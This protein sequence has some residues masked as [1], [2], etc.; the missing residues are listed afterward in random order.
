MKEPEMH[1][2]GENGITDALSLCGDDRTFMGGEIGS[3]AYGT[4]FHPRPD[5]VAMSSSTANDPS[6]KG[7]SA[8]C[9]LLWKIRMA[10]TEGFNECAAMER[11]RQ[12]EALKTL[13]ALPDDDI[14]FAPSGTD[15]EHLALKL[16]RGISG[17]K[18]LN[19]LIA[20]EEVGKGCV[21]AARGLHHSEKLPL[22]GEARIGHSIHGDRLERVRLESIPLRDREGRVIP[23]EEVD[24]AAAAL[25]KARISE[26]FHVILHFLDSSKTSLLGP[27][28]SLVEELKN[29][30][31]FC[32]DVFVDACQGRIRP[33]NIREYL[34]RSW[35][36]MITGSK[37]LSGPP[38]SAVLIVPIG[39]SSRIVA[40]RA[41]VPGW[42]SYFAESDWPRGKGPCFSKSAKTHNLGSIL[43][44]E[45]A[46]GEITA[47]EKIPERAKLR[48][49]QVFMD[50]VSQE[51]RSRSCLRLH[52]V[53]ALRRF[54]GGGWDELPTICSFGI[55]T[56]KNGALS[57]DKVRV[58]HQLMQLAVP[59]PGFANSMRGAQSAFNVPGK[60]LLG[61]PVQIG[62]GP[63]LKSLLRIS[64]SAV[65]ASKIYAGIRNGQS[66]ESAVSEKIKEVRM[67]LD[68]LECLLEYNRF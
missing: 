19:I 50:A 13:W 8:A 47:F 10:G 16:I 22:G 11:E 4:T 29:T 63:G 40:G 51:I 36:T 1:F 30:F 54:I 60:F 17:K 48:I 24:K 2:S 65:D 45:A 57:P 5:L 62:D 34:K 26:G 58:L 37:F 64:M 39:V 44:W 7:Y 38:F 6:P 12:R 23:L 66:V 53:P 68:K 28:L 33:E 14:Y 20:P 46:L 61:Q 59:F 3:T 35:M 55:S 25:V 27:S 21:F 67:A 52:S 31:P 56:R 18:L 49:T 42:A 32:L 41:Q 9:R 43:R 15:G